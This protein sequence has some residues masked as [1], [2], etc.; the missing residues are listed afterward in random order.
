VVFWRIP[1]EEQGGDERRPC[2]EYI[3][4][5]PT[6]REDSQMLRLIRRYAADETG[7]S[8]VE[9]G[10]VATLIAVAIIGA[11][12]TLGLNLVDKANEIAEAILEAG[13]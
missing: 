3:E 5:G 11:M 4:H 13:T 6:R 1:G 2:A 10:L 8:A 7:A 9:Y 12:T